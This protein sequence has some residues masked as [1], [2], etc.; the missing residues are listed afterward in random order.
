M[1]VLALVAVTSTWLKSVMFLP[2]VHQYSSSCHS[3]VCT[4]SDGY[5]KLVTV[6]RVT[7]TSYFLKCLQKYDYFPLEL[8]LK[9]FT[10]PIFSAFYHC[11]L[12]VTSRAVELTR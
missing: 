11:T 9:L 3:L 8:S 2:F 5:F 7:V 10:K 1:L 6:T 4:A 12:I